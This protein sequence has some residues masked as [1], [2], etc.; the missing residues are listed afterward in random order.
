[1][2]AEMGRVSIIM[3]RRHTDEVR[4]ILCPSLK[5]EAREDLCVLRRVCVSKTLMMTL[6]PRQ[7]FQ[8]AMFPML[9]DDVYAHMRKRVNFS[10][11][12]DCGP[13]LP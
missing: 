10:L 3:F 9:V 12:I 6:A 8:N 4:Q 2:A 5:V 13:Q 7:H 11:C 1:M